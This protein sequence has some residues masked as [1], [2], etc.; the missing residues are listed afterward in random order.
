MVC[1]SVVQA[2]NCSV[3]G[4][5]R[6]GGMAYHLLCLVEG[7]N[8]Q[9]FVVLEPEYSLPLTGVVIVVKDMVESQTVRLTRAS[10]QCNVRAFLP[11]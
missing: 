8:F 1:V 2:C 11:V 5:W 10:K 4:F 3:R 6:V 9:G 7:L